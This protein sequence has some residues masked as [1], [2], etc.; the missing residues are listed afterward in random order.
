MDLKAYAE[1][2]KQYH[3]APG[4]FVRREGKA[5]PPPADTPKPAADTPRKKSDQN[6][7]AERQPA[8]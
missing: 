5:T 2:S 8:N 1:G 6:D 3:A 4:K 7:R